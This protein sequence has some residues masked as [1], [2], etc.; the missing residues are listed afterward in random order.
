M[1]I[2]YYFLIPNP[3]FLVGADIIRPRN[4]HKIYRSLPLKIA[5]R[6]QNTSASAVICFFYAVSRSCISRLTSSPSGVTVSAIPPLSE[7]EYALRPNADIMPTST[8]QCTLCQV[9]F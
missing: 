3:Y 9:Q 1:G 8:L 4:L 6:R 7:V 2:V 5:P